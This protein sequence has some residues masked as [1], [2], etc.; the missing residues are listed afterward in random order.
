MQFVK[1]FF[2]KSF[3]NPTGP[4]KEARLYEMTQDFREYEE[5]EGKL[6]DIWNTRGKNLEN[7]VNHFVKET[8]ATIVL[9]LGAQ[10]LHTYDL[11]EL[12]P[13]FNNDKKKEELEQL[14]PAM[15]FCMEI[16]RYEIL[17]FIVQARKTKAFTQGAEHKKEVQNLKMSYT[18]LLV[19]YNGLMQ[20]FV[21]SKE[22]TLFNKV[23][24]AFNESQKRD[25]VI[26]QNFDFLNKYVT[27]F[28]KILSDT[29]Y[30]K[31]LT[32]KFDKKERARIKPATLNKP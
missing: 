6:W 15:D 22:L 23:T 30:G 24:K 4:T 2:E 25:P 29:K 1:S 32:E 12:N 26:T 10:L 5:Q 20:E 27:S 3:K 18:N 13:Y 14:K 16:Y 28:E 31:S 8:Q 7:D 21:K 11:Q 17:P 9:D 19:E